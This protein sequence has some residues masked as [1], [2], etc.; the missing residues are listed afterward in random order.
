MVD[1]EQ[2]VYGILNNVLGNSYLIT[3][4]ANQ[5]PVEYPCVTVE[6]IDNFVPSQYMDGSNNDNFSAVTIEINIYTVTQPNGSG[7]KAQAKSIFSNIDRIMC[8][9]GFRRTTTSPVTFAD[10]TKYRIAVRYNALISN[11]QKIYRR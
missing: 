6:E 9:H 1:S 10:N 4:D 8:E 5:T 7:K 11:D 3:T 2:L